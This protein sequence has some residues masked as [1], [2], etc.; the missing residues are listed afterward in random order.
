MNIYDG[1]VTQIKS[2]VSSVH[3][4]YVVCV[5]KPA[6]NAMPVPTVDIHAFDACMPACHTCPEVSHA[7]QALHKGAATCWLAASSRT[8]SALVRYHPVHAELQV[9]PKHAR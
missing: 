2:K 3:Q 1:A 9:K 6:S 4:P 5:A 8:C 7:R